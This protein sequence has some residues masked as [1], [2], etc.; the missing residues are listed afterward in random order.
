MRALSFHSSGQLMPR[1]E[2]YHSDPEP[3]VGKKGYFI[4]LTARGEEV[5]KLIGL[6][7]GADDYPSKPFSPPVMLARIHVM[8]CRPR[9]SPAGR[10]PS[11]ES[12]R[13]FRALRIDVAGR[14]VSP[15]RGEAVALTRTDFDVLGAVSARPK[16][17]FS[18]CQL[19]VP[20]WD[21]R[22]V[23]AA[24]LVD[25]HVGDLRRK[26]GDDL[27]SPRY[28]LTVRGIGYMGEGI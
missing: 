23:G 18:R 12:P 27:G 7:V 4:M 28:V 5:D 8:L 10:Q 19:S 13:M 11:Q 1:W 25:L 22:W 2:S 21:Q 9:V 24:H 17:V 20:V 16:L 3:G 14:E 6:A 15:R 26:L